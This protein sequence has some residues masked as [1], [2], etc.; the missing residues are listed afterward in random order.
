MAWPHCQDALAG[1][2]VESY[3]CYADRV[4]FSVEAV[5]GQAVIEMMTSQGAHTHVLFGNK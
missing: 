1:W 4:R 5:A 3:S 2:S